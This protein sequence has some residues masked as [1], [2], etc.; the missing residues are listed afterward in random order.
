MGVGE[1]TQQLLL[2]LSLTCVWFQA[3]IPGSS[4][5]PLT[6]VPG[7]LTPSFVFL[8]ALTHTGKLKISKPFKKKTAQKN[9]VSSPI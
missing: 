3:F 2:L 1:M 6:A 7:S 5:Q 8:Q 4:Q 9:I